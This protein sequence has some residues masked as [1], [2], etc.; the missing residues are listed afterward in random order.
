MQKK[1][2]KIFSSNIS[3][4]YFLW[5][6]KNDSYNVSIITRILI[7]RVKT[8]QRVIA[9]GIVAVVTVYKRFM[10]ARLRAHDNAALVHFRGV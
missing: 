7:E 3:I 1:R 8:I 9:E 2:R 4:I 10:T 5:Q 6:S